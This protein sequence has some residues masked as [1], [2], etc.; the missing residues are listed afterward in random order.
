MTLSETPP[1]GLPA[2]ATERTPRST[3]AQPLLF[4]V[5]FAVPTVTLPNVPGFD[6]TQRSSHPGPEYIAMYVPG[7]GW[8]K[9][10]GP[11]DGTPLHLDFAPPSPPIPI[12]LSLVPTFFALF[13][14]G[15]VPSPSPNPSTSPTAS[16]SPSP[17]PSS[18]PTASPTPVPTPNVLTVSP[19][20]VPLSVGQ[21]A[22]LTIQE[23]GYTGSF[24]ITNGCP[25]GVATISAPGNGPSATATITAHGAGTTCTATVSDS[26]G[27]HKHVSIT[28]TGTIAL[29]GLSV[30]TDGSTGMPWSGQLVAGITTQVG[31]S[32]SEVGY[33]STLT[34]MVRSAG[35]S[36]DPITNVTTP[37]S[38]C[39]AI[40]S[41]A[42]PGPATT[43]TIT[44]SAVGACQVRVQ[45]TFGNTA[46]LWVLPANIVVHLQ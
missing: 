2:S 4:I 41:V 1:Q 33:T 14:N 26:N 45:D 5:M 46:D 17:H 38:N 37:I 11:L 3:A 6:I 29:S 24:A 36:V 8:Q 31:F 23:A 32:A 15:A 19:T 16:A 21:T 30:T 25:S 40:I 12:T 35:Y 44:A 42:P 20:S 34:A 28:V 7:T 9:V 39:G 13:G 10:E 43:F 22:P 18:S 27:Q